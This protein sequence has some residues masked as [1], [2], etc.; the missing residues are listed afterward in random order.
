MVPIH[1]HGNHWTLAVLKLT[2]KTVGGVIKTFAAE[3]LYDD[4]L[5]GGAGGILANLQHWLVDEFEDKKKCKAEPPASF[6]LPIIN[7]G[8]HQNNGHDC[9]VFTCQTARHRARELS[10]HPAFTNNDMPY[11]RRRMVEEIIQ[12]TVADRQGGC[13]HITGFGNR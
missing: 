12:K 7:Q 3:S 13:N 5:G 2:V 8:P 1:I 9:G 6:T 11:F 4:S 10:R